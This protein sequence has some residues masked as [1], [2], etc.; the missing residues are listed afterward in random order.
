MRT[1]S[2]LAGP[3]AVSLLLGVVLPAAPALAARASAPVMHIELVH[4]TALAPPRGTFVMRVQLQ[5]VPADGS[6]RLVVHQR[7]RSRS[8]LDA[9]M[10]GQGLRSRI[11]ATVTPLAALPPQADGSRRVTLSLDPPTGGLP[12]STEGVYPVELIAEDAAGASGATL[13]THL[14]VPPATGNGA[15]ALG[16]AVVADISAPSALQPDG[17]VRL[18]GRDKQSL[19][20]LVMGLAGAPGVAATIAATPETLD[21]LS[22][23]STPG[24]AELVDALRSA[25]A[26]RLVLD[27]P[28]V[29]VSPDALAKAG[30]LGELSAQL[31]RGRQ[32]LSDVLG[33]E[34]THTV[35]LAPP[36]LGADGLGVLA[37]SGVHRIVVGADR[38]AALD[39]GLISYSLAQPFKLVGPDDRRTDPAPP[40]IDALAT[41]AGVLARLA[42][43]GSPALVASRVLS[44]LAFLRLEQPSVARSVV[45]PLR[46]GTAAGVVQLLLEGLAAGRPVTALTLDEAFDHAQPLLDRGGSAVER[47]LLPVPA[48]SAPA[49]SASDARAVKA[50]RADLGSFIALVGRDSPRSDPIARHLLLATATSLTTGQRREHL[51]AVE[52]AIDAVASEVTTPATFTLTLTARDGTIPLTITN[53]SGLPLHVSVRLTSSKLE[54]PDGDTIDRTLTQATTR[55]DLAVR[56]RATGAFPVEVDVVTPDG[57]RT[58]ATTR[59]TVRS[60]A[61]SGVGLILSGGAGLFLIVWWARHWRRTRRSAKLVAVQGHPAARGD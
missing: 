47:H 27:E 18:G 26:G 17:T 24:D 10:E 31:S 23:S 35:A 49:I 58:L 15:P 4:Q 50:A 3:L 45:I 46:P 32:V 1:R 21:A 53:R 36:D 34:P 9:S 2:S 56:A 25:A 43:D 40:A 20:D 14:I 41:D 61:V 7:V 5:G 57:R 44:E 28:Y 39:P 52:T 37:Y 29:G 59:Y 48:S 8:E 12:L 11:F 42:S 19:D 6:L 22:S 16:V 13:V 51:H 38:V 55:I 60:T 33:G 30:L 54:F